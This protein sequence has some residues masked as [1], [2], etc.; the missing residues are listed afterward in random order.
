DKEFPNVKFIDPGNIVAQK[1]FKI[2]KN[3]QSKRNSLKIFASGD[4]KRFQKKLSRIGI[5]NKVNSLSI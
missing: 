4:V 3:N 1:V 2:I 5:K